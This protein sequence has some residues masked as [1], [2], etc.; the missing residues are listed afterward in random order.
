M[1][2]GD[3]VKKGDVLCTLFVAG[4]VEDHGAKPADRR[5]DKEQIVSTSKIVDAA[6]ANVKAA[7]SRLDAAAAVV[8]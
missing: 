2:I 3:K 5:L 4:L 7:K 6:D 8:A 1:D